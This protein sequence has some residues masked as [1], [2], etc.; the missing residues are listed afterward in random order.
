MG[1][2]QLFFSLTQLTRVYIHGTGNN[3]DR[4]DPEAPPRS[5][6]PGRLPLFGSVLGLWCPWTWSLC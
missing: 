3:P 6:G 5:C 4:K 2:R 1:S